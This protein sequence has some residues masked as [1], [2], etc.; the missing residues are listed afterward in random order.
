MS[1]G[2]CP[3]SGRLVPEPDTRTGESLPDRRR[4]AFC[5]FCVFCG[6]KPQ[7]TQKTQKTE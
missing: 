4:A 6:P 2:K 7:N 5:V 3:L 1:P